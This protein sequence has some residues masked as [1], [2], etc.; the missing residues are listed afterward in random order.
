MHWTTKYILQTL[1]VICEQKNQNTVERN[2]SIIPLSFYL[3]RETKVSVIIDK[4]SNINN[5]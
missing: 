4:L 1:F 2:L 3:I 5:T